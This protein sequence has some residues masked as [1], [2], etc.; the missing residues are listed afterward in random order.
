MVRHDPNANHPVGLLIE[1][2][3][4]G[5]VVRRFPHDHTDLYG[6]NP[7]DLELP[8]S[9]GPF[10]LVHVR[11]HNALRTTT[12]GSTNVTVRT[13]QLGDDDDALEVALAHHTDSLVIA[14]HGACP[15]QNN[16]DQPPTRSAVGVHLGPG[17]PLNRAC[18]IPDAKDRGHVMKDTDGS[19]SRDRPQHTQQRADLYAA[20][21]GLMEATTIATR[22]LPARGTRSQPKPF[23]LH[24]VVV[25][26]DSAYVVE[27]VAGGRNGEPPH[28][29]KWL[30]NGWK[31]TKGEK[32]KN[33]DLWDNLMLTMMSLGQVGVAVE[34]WQ[35]PKKENKEADKLAKLGLEQE[36]NFFD[37]KSVFG[38]EDHS[39]KADAVGDELV[40]ME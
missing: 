25:K 37:E 6:E 9:H 16:S 30:A 24:H 14:V 1:P 5:Y 20:I 39:K 36:V 19:D 32:V 28:M 17:N 31:N 2:N 12:M 40:A 35:V 26:S 27:G 29:N 3:S 11:C 21:A 22:G 34:F 23:K 8:G 10:N 38:K 4:D 7:A 13:I 18:R 33:E 15:P